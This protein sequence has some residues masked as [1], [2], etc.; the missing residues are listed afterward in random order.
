MS[1]SLHSQ[2][3][4]L[5]IRVLSITLDTGHVLLGEVYGSP[6]N[7][8]VVGDA[9]QAS[10]NF[11]ALDDDSAALNDLKAQCDTDGATI[12]ATIQAGSVTNNKFTFN[13]KSI[14]PQ[15]FNLRD[16]G[17]STEMEMQESMA[18]ASVL[19]N[20]DDFSMGFS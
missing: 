17:P 7:I 19:G 20:V 12:D 2:S 5:K 3:L 6:Y 13:L 4:E 8:A 15:A 11:S 9:R 14:Q 10:I 18:H 16:N 1:V